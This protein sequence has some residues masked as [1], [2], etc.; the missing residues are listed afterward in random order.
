MKTYAVY[1]NNEQIGTVRASST[2]E[3]QKKANREYPGENVVV[4]PE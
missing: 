3:A 1:I 2:K 4:L